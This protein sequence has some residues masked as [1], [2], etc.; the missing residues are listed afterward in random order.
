MLCVAPF[1]KRTGVLANN[2]KW[3]YVCVCVP[4]FV[5]IHSP[6]LSSSEL[7]LIT[8]TY[9]VIKKQTHQN[10]V[11]LQSCEK[12]SLGIWWLLCCSGS[13]EKKAERWQECSTVSLKQMYSFC[14]CIVDCLGYIMGPS[15]PRAQSGTKQEASVSASLRSDT[16]GLSCY[17]STWM[18]CGTH[19][20]INEV[21]TMIELKKESILD[22][23]KVSRRKK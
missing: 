7:P 23:S 11:C 13:C 16:H 6:L 10:R 21:E 14:I 15:L 22:R 2:S 4:V 19:G 20:Q 17:I 8:E 18:T 5:F 1:F 12:C 3:L 9:F